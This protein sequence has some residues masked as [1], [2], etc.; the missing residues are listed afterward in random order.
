MAEN[1]LFYTHTYKGED[2]L[3]TFSRKGKY[4]KILIAPAHQPRKS[5]DSQ[6]VVYDVIFGSWATYEEALNSGIKASE[7]FVDDRQDGLNRNG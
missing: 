2:L 1:W 7:K 5:A 6:S 4:Q 3:I